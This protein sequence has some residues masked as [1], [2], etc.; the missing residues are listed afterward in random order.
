MTTFP[1]VDIQIIE[2]KDVLGIETD[3]AKLPCIF[4][5]CKGEFDRFREAR[6]ATHIITVSDLVKLP[7]CQMHAEDFQG[8]KR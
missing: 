4:C 8:D 1:E 6:R 3:Y 5:M 2:A 7:L